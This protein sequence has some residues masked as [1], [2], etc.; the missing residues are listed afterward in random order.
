MEA[1][2][3]VTLISECVREKIGHAGGRGGGRGKVR[4]D[5]SELVGW[6]KDTDVVPLEIRKLAIL[7]ATAS[8]A[9]VPSGL[10]RRI[11]QMSCW[12]SLYPRAERID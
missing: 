8:A 7:L 4:P 9:D 10:T 3:K 12:I 2:R 5:I 1:K 11:S 6:A